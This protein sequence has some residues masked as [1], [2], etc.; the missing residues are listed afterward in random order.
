MVKGRGQT[1]GFCS[2]VVR[3]ISLTPALK[4]LNIAQ[5]M[6]LAGR[7][8]LLMSGSHVYPPI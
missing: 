8:P 4:F 7:R 6:H 3:L 2:N 5:L 1:G